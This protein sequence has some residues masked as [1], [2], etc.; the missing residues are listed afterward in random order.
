MT[1]GII[2]NA[3]KGESLGIGVLA[4]V[5][6]SK[7]KRRW[8][9]SDEPGI[10]LQYGSLGAARFACRRLTRNEPR[11]VPFSEVVRL[12]REQAREIEM[13]EAMADCEQGWDA[14]K[15]WSFA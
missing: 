14:H 1:F 8:W 15:D 4:L 10:A 6:R 13:T 12:L 9:T 11:V 3:R 5:D 2:C 7:S